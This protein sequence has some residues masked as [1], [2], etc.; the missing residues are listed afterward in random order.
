MFNVFEVFSC[1]IGDSRVFR[2]SGINVVRG[3]SVKSIFSSV[4]TC[5]T[6][7]RTYLFLN[8]TITESGAGNLIQETNR[9]TK[10]AIGSAVDPKT[11]FNTRKPVVF[12]C[13][14][15]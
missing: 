5:F 13:T 9:N 14:D 12:Q 15:L 7:S 3:F 1:K 6:K 2:G 11:I 10:V 8:M 4:L